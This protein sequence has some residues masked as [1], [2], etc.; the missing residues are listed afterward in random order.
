[1]Y[2]PRRT[3]AYFPDTDVHD[4]RRS[5]ACLFGPPSNPSTER[6]S[7]FGA[8]IATTDDESRQFLTDFD[9]HVEQHVQMLKNRLKM[10]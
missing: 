10:K 9:S 8:A 5:E 7:M 6:T 4:E 3:F 1:M 2:R